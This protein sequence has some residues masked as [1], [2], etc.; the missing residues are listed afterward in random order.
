LR[1]QVTIE[2]LL[3]LSASTL[4]ILLFVVFAWD[5]MVVSYNVQQVKVGRAAVFRTV[6]EINDAYYLGIGTKKTFEVIIPEATIFDKSVMSGRTMILNVGGSDIIAEA[7]VD[8]NGEWSRS[9]G[10]TTI[11]IEVEN[12]LVQVR[13]NPE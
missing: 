5:Q 13:V 8:I 12:N 11:E 1:A 7:L 3:I 10:R 6:G 4:M 2:T 9:T